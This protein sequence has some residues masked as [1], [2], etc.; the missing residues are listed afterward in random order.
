MTKR[1]TSLILVTLFVIS[2]FAF[3]GCNGMEKA[4]L[5]QYKTDAKMDVELYLMQMYNN[6]EDYSKE[7]WDEIF[8][9]RN[10]GITAIDSASNKTEIDEAVTNTK[11]KFDNVPKIINGMQYVEVDTDGIAV[12][13][14][15]AFTSGVENNR[16]LL[17]HQNSNVVF[18]CSVDNGTLRGNSFV[19]ARPNEYIAWNSG[20][21]HGNAY[22]DIVIK[23]EDNIIGYVVIEAVEK[24][25]KSGFFSPRVLKSALFPQID[26]Q[27]QRISQQQVL[28]LIDKVKI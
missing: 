11:K 25:D 3:V 22:I 2:L 10:N 19:E 23:E 4:A 24:K 28:A 17:K 14:Y 16:I 5:E 26:G 13:H 20:G 21:V 18:E 9:I 27:Y 12:P 8:E 15:W 6:S 1:I 7:K